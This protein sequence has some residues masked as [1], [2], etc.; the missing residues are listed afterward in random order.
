ME[1]NTIKN[2]L[3]GVL[4]VTTLI[5]SYCAYTQMNNLHAA[6]RII[7]QQKTN[8]KVV[9]FTESLI[10]KVLKSTAPVDFDT[11]LQ[12]ENMVRDLNDKAI[13]DEWN[14]FVNSTDANQAQIEI[15]NLLD[16][17]IKRIN[18]IN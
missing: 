10:A 16:L 5:L 8:T 13:L 1:H 6:E 4:A 3:I 15:K 12:L 2:L 18:I 11:R 7:D 9:I 14:K 17:L